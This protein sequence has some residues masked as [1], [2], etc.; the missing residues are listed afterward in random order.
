MPASRLAKLTP[1]RSEGLLRRERLFEQLD[2]ARTRPAVW[3]A[4]PPGAG[5]TSLLA[6]YL[7]ARKLPTLWYQLDS[8]DADPATFF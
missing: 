3:I 5:K 7:D 6:S 1:P 2:Q 8:G 4:A